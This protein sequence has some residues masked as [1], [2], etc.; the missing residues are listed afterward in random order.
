MDLVAV[1]AHELGH[2]IGRDHGDDHDVMSPTLEAGERLE[3]R[4]ERFGGT[5][6]LSLNG[7]VW[8]SVGQFDATDHSSENLKSE[9]SNLKSPPAFRIRDAL[10]ARLDD[11]AGALTD[12]YDLFFTEEGSSEEAEDGLDVWGRLL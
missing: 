5:D 12:D 9:I 4:G 6:P 7:H 10:F 3:V 8:S 2:V 11:R 1:L